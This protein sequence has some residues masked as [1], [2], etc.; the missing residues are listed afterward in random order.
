ME[1]VRIGSQAPWETKIGYSRAVRVGS[2]IHVSGTA[3]VSEDGTVFAPGNPFRQAGRCLEL[4]ERSLA[5]LDCNRTAIVRT[6]MFVIDISQWEEFGRAHR[7]FFGQAFP[8]T[9]MVEISRLI[10]HDMLIEI[11]AEAFAP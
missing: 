7:E 4:I 6:R 2:Q 1:F 10:E 8:S 5:A 11:E 9:T 3:A